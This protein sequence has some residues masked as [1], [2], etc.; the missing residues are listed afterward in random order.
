MFE[1]IKAGRSSRSRQNRVSGYFPKVL[2]SSVLA[3]ALFWLITPRLGNAQAPA[4][5]W[6]TFLKDA[7][8][9][10]CLSLG[11]GAMAGQQLIVNT[12]PHFVRF[13]RSGTVVV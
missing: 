5:H 12:R 3:T 1:F 7:S 4:F 8:V 2:R 6:E 9:G 10:E 13:C 11:E